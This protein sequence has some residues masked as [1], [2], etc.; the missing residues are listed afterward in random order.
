MTAAIE[1]MGQTKPN[2]C[3]LLSLGNALLHLGLMD[4]PWDQN[5]PEFDRL[6]GD[7]GVTS[8]SA[9]QENL[10]DNYPRTT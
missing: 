1:Y 6:A 10:D 2:V 7:A 9:I 4:H 5:S 3:A 8:G